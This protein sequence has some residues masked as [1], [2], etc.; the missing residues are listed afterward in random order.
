MVGRSLLRLFAVPRSGS[1][2]LCPLRLARSA[3]AK[4]CHEKTSAHCRRNRRSGA[5]R[6]KITPNASASSW[7]GMV[8][9]HVPP[10]T[11]PAILDH[12]YRAC[13][14]GALTYGELGS[15]LVLSSVSAA[16]LRASF[17]VGWQNTSGPMFKLSKFD[18]ASSSGGRRKGQE[19]RAS[20][21]GC[22]LDRMGSV[23]RQWGD[24][25][26]TR[27]CLRALAGFPKSLRTA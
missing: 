2:G 7:T 6:H 15:Q 12:R 11:V 13:D 20:C 4:G 10:A 18:A 3:F 14:F 17:G 23:F 19:N 22:S 9:L 26:V 27:D 24:L 16:Q 5:S 1:V 8:A 25:L 21:V